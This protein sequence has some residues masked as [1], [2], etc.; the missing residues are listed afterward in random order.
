MRLQ[1]ALIYDGVV[2]LTDTFKQLGLEQIE[3][4]SIG[5]MDGNDT[6]WEKGMSI[7]NFMRNVS[8]GHY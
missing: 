2:L 5:C 3:P 4:V 1:T 6:T 8:F 7:S